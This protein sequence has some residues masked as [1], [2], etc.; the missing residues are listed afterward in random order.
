[1]GFTV[2]IPEGSSFTLHNIPFGVISTDANPEPH[3]ATAIGDYALD[4]PLY[5]HYRAS[6]DKYFV[7]LDCDTLHAI[8]NQPSLNTF[9]ALPSTTRTAIRAHLIEALRD[10]EVPESCLISLPEARMHLPMQIGG[11]SD[12]FC[13]LEHC[14][15]LLTGLDQCSPMTGG[16]VAPNFYHAPSVYNGRVSSVIPSPAP[17]RRPK[18]VM[19]D[20]GKGSGNPVYGPSQKLDF[21]LEMGYFVSTP[22][23]HGETMSIADAREHIFGFVLLN[24]WSSRD[25]QAFEM[26]PLGPF[27]SKGFGTS[28]S[29]WVVTLDALEPFACEPKHDH[30]ATEFEHLKW[31]EREVGTFDVELTAALVRDQKRYEV[32]KSNLRWLY[33]SPYQQLA[34]H[35]SAGCGL[36]AGDLLGSGTISGEREGELGCLFEATQGGEKPIQFEDGASLGYLEDHDEVVLE[37]WCGKGEDRIGFGECRG[38]LL[39]ASK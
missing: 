21:E 37:G 17:V 20:T 13:S 25:I 8:F 16:V 4:L 18:G 38:V 32:T 19:Y 6:D 28:I 39:P 3:C 34:H 23:A 2:T 29:P 7:P 26:N 12:F 27:H 15:N 30:S 22:I 36:G 14:Q 33:W 11:Y 5:F 35:A 10:S 24:D 9:A 31:K 1:M